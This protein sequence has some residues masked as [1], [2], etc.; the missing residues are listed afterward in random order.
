MRVHVVTESDP[1]SRAIASALARL[2]D[3]DAGYVG[4]S[5]RDLVTELR[6]RDGVLASRGLPPTS[7][8]QLL[9]VAWRYPESPRVEFV[10]LV[11]PSG[12]EPGRGLAL[13][14]AS[15]RALRD[16]LEEP[17]HPDARRLALRFTARRAP[18][19]APT[20]SVTGSLRAG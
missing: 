6:S 13:D 2:P 20:A 5:T 10:D 15:S 18:A 11:L 4:T 1:A 19:P 7:L 12:G 17:S 8:M 16:R 14:R 3:H 9:G